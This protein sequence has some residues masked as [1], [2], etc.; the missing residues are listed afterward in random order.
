MA[1]SKDLHLSFVIYII[2]TLSLIIYKKK[3]IELIKLFFRPEW[4]IS[5]ILIIGWSLY[6]LKYNAYGLL[7]EHNDLK[8]FKRATT[9]SIIAFIIALFA[10]IDL[11][12]PTFWFVWIISFYIEKGD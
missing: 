2:L 8:K 7:K 1:F 5:F 9:H 4:S 6:I 11:T 3:H 12:I 10:Y